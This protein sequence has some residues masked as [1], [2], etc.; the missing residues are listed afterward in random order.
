MT[1]QREAG[2]V[3]R[4]AVVCIGKIGDMIVSNFTI[5]KVRTTFPKAEILLVTLERSR[6]LLR[7]ETS[8]DRIR[9]FRKGLDIIPLL[10]D[11]RRFRAD[12][13]LDLNDNPSTTSTWL[14][15]FGGAR[16]T[17]GFAFE[18][19]RKFLSI[20]V[21]RP[22]DETM[23]IIQR[24]K[25]IMEATGVRFEQHE[26]IPL[27]AIGESEKAEVSKE[28]AETLPGKTSLIAVNLSA[29]SPSRYWAIENWCEL[30]LSIHQEHEELAFLLLCSPEDDHL[31]RKV[32][33]S[34]PGHSVLLPRYRTFHHFAAYIASADL[35]ISPDT[36]AIHI[37][38]AESVPVLGLY[39]AVEW[40]FWSWQPVNTIYRAMRPT[41]GLVSDIGTNEVL[42]AFRDLW[43]ETAPGRSRTRV[44][45]GSRVAQMNLPGNG[46]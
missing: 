15:R 1:V 29:G 11:V 43:R 35:L 24:R 9:F 12:L 40:N 31:A 41:Q 7:Y 25:R 23:H 14:A 8:A 34:L 19:N 33:A 38:S 26:L 30:L 10:A 37:A 20:A 13:L 44:G 32:A 6:D 42:N 3:R 45:A 36:S 5:R 39:P 18:S 27:I 16:T 4:V 22:A 28:L 46:R 17:V 21:E 2:N